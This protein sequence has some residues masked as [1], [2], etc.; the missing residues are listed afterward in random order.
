M[1]YILGEKH[2]FKHQI[3]QS[4]S[5][6]QIRPIYSHFKHSV[7]SNSMLDTYFSTKVQEVKANFLAPQRNSEIPTK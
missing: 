3:M 2:F 6:V 1:N 7:Y 5:D 4:T